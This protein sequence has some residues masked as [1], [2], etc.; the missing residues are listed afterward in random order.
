M[1]TSVTSESQSSFQYRNLI[2]RLASDYHVVAP[3]LP[4][5]G[6]TVVP[7]GF[8]YTFDNLA[9]AVIAFVQKLGLNSYAIYIHDY[10]SPVGFRL[11]LWRPKSI[12]AIIS[13]NGNA[14]VDGFGPE[15]WKPLQAYWKSGA[16]SDRNVLRGAFT[17]DAIKWQVRLPYASELQPCFTLIPGTDI[18]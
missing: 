10:G 2:D 13:Q 1:H 4:G 12:T 18:F 7:S 6:F 5:F 17:L 3:D 16:E 14:F 8:T 11:A 15:F 9:A